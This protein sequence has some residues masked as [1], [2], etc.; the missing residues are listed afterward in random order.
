M[1]Y[2]IILVLLLT[3]GCRNQ[4]N[5]FEKYTSQLQLIKTPVVFETIKYPEA[6]LPENYNKDLFERFKLEAA[7]SAYGKLYENNNSTGIIYT[8]AGD[9]AVPF[10]VTYDKTGTKLDSFNLFQNASGFDVE[11]ECYER[12]LLLPAQKIQ[13]RDSTIKW[14][15]NESGDDRIEGSETVSIKTFNY[16]IDKKGKIIKAPGK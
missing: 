6:Q 1:R 5:D 13:V 10:L 7:Q 2:P 15:L 8:V 9:V 11:S 3:F 14:K 12:V 4:N 16:A